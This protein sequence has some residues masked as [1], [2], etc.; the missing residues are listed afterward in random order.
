VRLVEYNLR[1]E[2]Q[3]MCRLH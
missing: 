1:N 2:L 3:V